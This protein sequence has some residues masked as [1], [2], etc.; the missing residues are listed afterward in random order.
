MCPCQVDPGS[1]DGAV[2]FPRARAR[3]DER[4]TARVTTINDKVYMLLAAALA[5]AVGSGDLDQAVHDAYDVFTT[6]DADVPPRPVREA[7]RDVT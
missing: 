7:H 5:D 4:G 6:L 2:G 3:H 1:H